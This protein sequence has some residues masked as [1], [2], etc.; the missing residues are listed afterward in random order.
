MESRNRLLERYYE[1][2]STQSE[3]QQLKELVDEDSFEKI[4]FDYFDHIGQIH[5]PGD[6]SRHKI[7]NKWYIG[8]AASLVIALISIF[9]MRDYFDRSTY[10]DSGSSTIHYQLPDKS[11]CWM[12]QNS[13]LQ[14]DNNFNA[15]NRSVALNGE[16]YFEVKKDKIPFRIELVYGA[17]EVIGTSFN[18]DA[19][20]GSLEI[21]V[22]SGL[23]KYIPDDGTDQHILPNQTLVVGKDQGMKIIENDRN[24]LSWKERELIFRNDSLNY[25]FRTVSKFLNKEFVVEVENIN[26]CTYTGTFYNPKESEI[27]ELLAYSLN[28]IFTETESGY[29]ITGEGC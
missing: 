14:F 6:H 10:V 20:D 13:T 9:S 8:I 24:L 7:S 16:A 28:L 18:V 15:D 17:V 29:I 2:I 12:N 4:T 11:E 27:T 23:V 21:S 26:H 19:R 3:E 1:G 22:L 25:V 5:Y